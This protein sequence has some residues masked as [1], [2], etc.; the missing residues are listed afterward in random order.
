MARGQPPQAERH[1]LECDHRCRARPPKEPDLDGLLA[2]ERSVIASKDHV[3]SGLI[4]KRRELSGIIDKLQR[5]LDQHRADLTHIDGVL[6]I[7]AT[8]LDP[9]KIKPKRIYRRNRYFAR[10]ELSRLCFGVLRT[11]AG[12]MLSTDDIAGRVIA[13]KGFDAGDATLRAAIRDQV[14]STVKR[15][16]RNGAI[17]KIGAGRASKWKLASGA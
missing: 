9:E 14:G 4:E 15:L 6:R 11:A 8:D 1:E 13:A 17:E 3:V 12:E 16:H 2:S 10:N 5:Q 7:L